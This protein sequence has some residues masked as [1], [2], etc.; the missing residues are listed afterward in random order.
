MF[1]SCTGDGGVSNAYQT[2]HQQHVHRSCRCRHYK[3]VSAKVVSSA[4]LLLLVAKI[5]IMHGV[6]VF[7]TDN[8]SIICCRYPLYL[9]AR[10]D[11]LHMM[12][13]HYIMQLLIAIYVVYHCL[14]CLLLLSFGLSLLFLVCLS[15]LFL[16][17][18]SLVAIIPSWLIAIIPLTYHYCYY[19]F[20]YRYY[21][22][23]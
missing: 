13:S 7:G 1:H 3:R 18:L 11:L 12:A 10:I 6:V 4:Q 15:L 20:A 5:H 2:D 14:A 17:G 22:F 19:S 9:S 23:A 16:H 21:S 8:I